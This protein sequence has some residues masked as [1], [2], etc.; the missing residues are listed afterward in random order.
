[1]YILGYAGIL[2]TQSNYSNP[3]GGLYCVHHVLNTLPQNVVLVIWSKEGG[4]IINQHFEHK[5]IKYIFS[6]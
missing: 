3:P 5:Y 4:L 2:F 6:L 1:M